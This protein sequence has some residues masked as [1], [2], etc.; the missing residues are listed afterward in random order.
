M[1]VGREGRGVGAAPA[2]LFAAASAFG[3]G[4]GERLHRIRGGQT[5]RYEAMGRASLEPSSLRLLAGIFI[6]VGA[7]P[8]V[9]G[10]EI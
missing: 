7:A 3:H 6:G 5:G 2:A 1:A 9:A 8:A 4:G 10:D